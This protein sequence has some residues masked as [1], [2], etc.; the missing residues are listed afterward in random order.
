MATK[1]TV[2]TDME[3]HKNGK[4]NFGYTRYEDIDKA[5]PGSKFILN[6][7]NDEDWYKSMKN[8]EQSASFKKPLIDRLKK[9]HRQGNYGDYRKPFKEAALEKKR[10]HE[11]SVRTYFK[12][13]PDDLL[14]VDIYDPEVESKMNDF[15]GISGTWG[16]KGK[17]KY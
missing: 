14:E 2:F 15:F 8:H 7:R 11:N 10:N 5:V 16:H 4:C 3:A 12:D 13:R 17:G 9:C 1:A 6:T